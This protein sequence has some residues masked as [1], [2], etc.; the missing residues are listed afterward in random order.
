MLRDA[1]PAVC[2]GILD[3]TV[4]PERMSMHRRIAMALALLLAMAV[5]QPTTAAPTGNKLLAK[6]LFEKGELHYQQGEFIKALDYYKR[7]HKIYR[8]PAFIFNIAQCHRQLKHWTKALFFYRLFLSERPAA[9]NRVEVRRRIKQMER[10]VAEQAALSK[11]V[12]RV[13]I[14]TRPEGALVRV[15]RFSGPSAGTTPVI[16]KLSAGEHLVLLHRKGYEKAHKT[17]SVKAGR[18][19]MLIVTLKP[20]VGPRRAEPRRAEPRRAEPR[21]TEP[22]RGVTPDPGTT[23]ALVAYKPFWKRWWFWTGLAVSAVAVGLGTVGGIQAL[24][25]H[26]E[27]MDT[28]FQDVQRGAE[29]A[30]LAADILL[31][32]G[33]AVAIATTIGAI[34]VHMRYKKKLRERVSPVSVTPSCGARGCGLWVYGRF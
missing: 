30:A 13:S 26:R 27:Y 11:Q 29:D 33:A 15:D 3:P 24:K 12:G 34:I 6:K 21:R 20:L 18:I 9:S 5:G 23:A 32:G 8:H 1:S 14:I 19:A 2:C 25:D 17:V 7:A 22:R 16:L 31:F 28:G 4:E 10:K